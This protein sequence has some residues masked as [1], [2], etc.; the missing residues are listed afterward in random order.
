MT[1]QA[2]IE[3]DKKSRI[4]ENE[5]DDIPEIKKF[6]YGQYYDITST[7]DKINYLGNLD[8]VYKNKTDNS[9]IIVQ[10]NKIT[11]DPTPENLKSVIDIAQDKGWQS[12]KI[13]GGKKE[14][15][16]ELWFIAQMRGLETT[17]YT[18]DKSD[19]ARLEQAK[20]KEVLKEG[21]TFVPKNPEEIKQEFLNNIPSSSDAPIK[22][23]LSEQQN[24][25]SEEQI[26]Q[27][28]KKEIIREATKLF[29]LNTQ[30]STAFEQAIDEQIAQAKSQGLHL[31]PKEK[32]VAISEKIQQNLPQ[33]KESFDK[34]LSQEKKALYKS[35]NKA[36]NIKN[37]S[38]KER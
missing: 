38:E 2:N 6:N 26:F 34:A 4:V 25:M 8:A 32:I 13:S 21:L 11:F 24:N 35:N 17:G 12:I 7:F 36:E 19:L 29:G 10:N 3:N 18:P 9:N 23:E 30:E 31:K 1:E 14:T 28:Q 27:E 20:A 15:Q 16:A 33:V 22:K 37:K 5:K